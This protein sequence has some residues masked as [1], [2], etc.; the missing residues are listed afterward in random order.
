M[1]RGGRAAWD[2]DEMLEIPDLKNHSQVVTDPFLI[3]Q[4]GGRVL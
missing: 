1:T 3:I 4:T 2:L